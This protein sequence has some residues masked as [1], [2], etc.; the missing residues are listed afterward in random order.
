MQRNFACALKL[1]CLGSAPDTTNGLWSKRRHAADATFMDPPPQTT[2][3]P[4]PT[5]LDSR[6]RLP[7]RRSI[8]LTAGIK[9]LP[10]KLRTLSGSDHPCS[11]LA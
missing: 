2:A 8:R 10:L 3:F 4:P 7:L 5:V 11:R 9:G 1:D 6:S